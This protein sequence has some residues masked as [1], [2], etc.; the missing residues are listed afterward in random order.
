MHG[1]VASV[2]AAPVGGPAPA[3]C[4]LAPAIF[5]GTIAHVRH[6]PVAHAFHYRLFM[7]ALDADAGTVP[8]RWSWLA[9][10]RRADHLGDPAEPLGAAVRRRV[11]AELPGVDVARI[12]LLTHLAQWG[13]RFNPVSF[14]FCSDG[15]GHPVA[16]VLEVNNTPWGEQHAY[17]LDCRAAAAAGPGGRALAFELDK[18]FHVSPFMQMGLRYGFEFLLDGAHVRV[19]MACHDAA[20]CL[21]R[22]TLDLRA[23]ARR[24]IGAVLLR[25]P[26]MTWRVTAG[27]YWQ[28]L[29]LWRK[30]APLFAHPRQAPAPEPSATA[31]GGDARR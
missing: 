24:G 16:I 27:I 2:A 18:A 9:R 1:A 6:A 22:A 3:A 13:H 21:F 17:V 11:A 15:G 23:D 10:L 29:Q 20:Q 31:A 28:A 25:Y 30:G 5:E 26:L 8:A 7:S 19:V 12:V 14:Y 4:V